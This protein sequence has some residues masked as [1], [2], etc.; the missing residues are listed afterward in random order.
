MPPNRTPGVGPRGIDTT[1]NGSNAM[2]TQEQRRT[3]LSRGYVHLRGVAGGRASDFEAFVWGRLE[4]LHGIRRH[5]RATWGHPAPWV[6]LKNFKDAELL[7]S[8]T[9]PDLCSAIDELLGTGNWKKPRHWGGFLVNLP[10]PDENDPWYIPTGGWHVDYHYTYDRAPLFG[11]R[12]FSFLSDVEP[13][14][15]GTLVVSGSHRVVADHVRTLSTEERSGGHAK[16][17]DRMHASLPW[18]KRLTEGNERDPNRIP[19]FMEQRDRVGD[20]EVRV[21]QLC[22]K[23]GDVVLMHPWVVHTG[24]PIRSD[25]PRFMLAKNLYAESVA[26]AA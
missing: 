26:A 19:T 1:Q 12:V 6:G 16:V 9:T 25:K 15:A 21:E 7:Q 10:K 5:D 18:F 17:R 20:V 4:E 8:F 14:G 22:G 2:L 11:L 24:S 23:P 3:F 13:R